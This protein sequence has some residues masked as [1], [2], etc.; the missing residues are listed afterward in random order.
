MSSAT[1]KLVAELHR[2]YQA[3]KIFVSPRKPGLRDDPKLDSLVRDLSVALARDLKKELG[4]SG[5]GVAEG[6]ILHNLKFIVQ[7]SV[8]CTY[9]YV[10]YDDDAGTCSY[11]GS[12]F[13]RNCA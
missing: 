11:L 6:H 4:L 2:R 5:T 1:K 13:I 10:L 7:Y 9:Y 3:N 12:R 8:G